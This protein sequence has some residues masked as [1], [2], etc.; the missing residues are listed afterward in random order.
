MA[1]ELR[2]LRYVITVAETGQL[3]RAAAR[4]HVAQPALSQSIARVERELGATLFVRHPNGVTPTPAG[5]AFVE[6]A[7]AAVNAADTAV[8]AAR[9][10]ARSS[11]GQL[12]FGFLN[13]GP[14]IAEPL[15][16]A[17]TAAHP[18]IDVVVQ[19]IGFARQVDAILDG[20][21]DAAVLCPGPPDSEVETIPIARTSMVVFV[22]NGH[23][24]ASRTQLTFADVDDET[25]L[26]PGPG[27]PE[28][29]MDIWWLTERRGRRPKVGRHASSSVNES[30][31]GILAGEAIVL[32][33]DF[34][35]PPYPIPGIT[36]IPLTDV[37]APD[38]ELAYLPNRATR[39]TKLLADVARTLQPPSSSS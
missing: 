33:P 4:L 35:V 18:E 8:T 38:I 23:R 32:A 27:L 10:H 15:L 34:F 16:S 19:E 28:W 26:R 30:I 36:T 39:A 11:A 13:G 2:H 14:A 31:A 7:R 9:Q 21:V 12:L 5:E 1:I 37:D 20:T 22:A 17:F 29:W 25:Y 3:T 6:H 24:L